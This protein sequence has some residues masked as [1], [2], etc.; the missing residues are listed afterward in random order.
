MKS[1]KLNAEKVI[2]G[3]AIK[4]R[5]DILGLSQKKLAERAHVHR[6]YVC[7][8]ECCRRNVSF[9]VLVRLCAALECSLHDLFS[10]FGSKD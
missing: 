5:R 3:H 8:V 1:I 6:T 2:L 9:D 10:V 7:D 4:E